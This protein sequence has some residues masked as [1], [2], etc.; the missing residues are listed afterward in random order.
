MTPFWFMPEE[1]LFLREKKSQQ[2]KLEIKAYQ[3]KIYDEWEMHRE[4]ELP[5]GKN[6][7]TRFFRAF[8]L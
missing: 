2:K 1:L 5:S 8:R 4:K 7:G 3:I 6:K